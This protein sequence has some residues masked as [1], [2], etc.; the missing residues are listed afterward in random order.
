MLRTISRR[1]FSTRPAYENFAQSVFTPAQMRKVLPT[2][3]CSVC[4]VVWLLNTAAQY[5]VAT[6]LAYWLEPEM[7]M[8]CI[9]IIAGAYNFI[10]FTA[11]C[12][13]I[14]VLV[15]NRRRLSMPSAIVHLLLPLR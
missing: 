15:C 14:G 12:A 7:C 3:V 5:F 4:L 2:Q 9:V 11:G 6:W 10:H 13:N 8:C 1:A